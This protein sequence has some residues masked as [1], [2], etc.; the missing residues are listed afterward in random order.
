MARQ[1]ADGPT[2]HWGVPATGINPLNA[3]KV[4]YSL[5]VDS[6]SGEVR[7]S[8]VQQASRTA[9]TV[10][11]Y[12]AYNYADC[13]S[14]FDAVGLW[15]PGYGWKG[16][17]V[18]DVVSHTVLPDGTEHLSY[19]VGS[20]LTDTVWSCDPRCGWKHPQVV[21]STAVRGPAGAVVAGTLFL[22]FYDS[23]NGVSCATLDGSGWHPAVQVASNVLPEPPSVA[24]NR[25]VLY[26]GFRR[27][28]GGN[29]EF[30]LKTW[31]AVNGWAA[32]EQ[33]AGF[34][35][36]S[37]VALASGD[38]DPVTPTPDVMYAVFRSTV[39]GQ[40]YRLVYRTFDF[41]G[42]SWSNETPIGP[43]DVEYET[44]SDPAARVFRGNLHIASTDM[45]VSQGPVAYRSCCTY[46]GWSRNTHLEVP[47]NSQNVSLSAWGSRL[48]LWYRQPSGALARSWKVSR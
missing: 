19:R 44:G 33:D 23:L 45:N 10:Q 4:W 24:V 13:V 38:E 15:S 27:T 41:S 42:G 21:D 39:P 31:D 2:A 12:S 16:F 11:G 29:S 48:T 28:V 35:T 18:D 14:A 30:F 7:F 43:P 6:L 26:L 8:D 22:C 46:G 1:P 34:F 17:E 40:V 9:C 5:L 47:L 3:S 36:R 37:V 32:P 20:I 25:N